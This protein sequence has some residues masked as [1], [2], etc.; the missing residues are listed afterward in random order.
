MVNIDQLDS[1]G[2]RVYVLC[3]VPEGNLAASDCMLAQ[4]IALERFETTALAIAVQRPGW[5]STR[6]AGIKS[7]SRGASRGLP[8]FQR[9]QSGFGVGDKFAQAGFGTRFFGKA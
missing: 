7:F 4:K 9:V 5:C 3:V 1:T 2:N 8:C 6:F